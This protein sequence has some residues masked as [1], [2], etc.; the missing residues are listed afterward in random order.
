MK[1]GDKHLNDRNELIEINDLNTDW[2]FYTIENEEGYGEVRR[3]HFKKVFGEPL[4]DKFRSQH[5]INEEKK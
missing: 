4:G 2:V 3:T 1:I 5:S